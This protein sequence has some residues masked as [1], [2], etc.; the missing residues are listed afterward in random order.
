[1][2]RR[3]STLSLDAPAT[4]HGMDMLRVPKVILDV[5]PSGILRRDAE[6]AWTMFQDARTSAV[7]VVTLP[8]EMPTT[9][10]VELVAS[11]RDELGL[12]LFAV[13]VNGIS[14]S[15]SRPMRGGFSLLTRRSTVWMPDAR[16]G[17]PAKRS[18]CGRFSCHARTN[19][20]RECVAP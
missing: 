14:N 13:V 6:K 2:D 16:R 4:G 12:P 3:A 8:E 15:S 10:T 7:L 17:L 5:A 19:P 18:R 11:V 9:E 20:S 1:M